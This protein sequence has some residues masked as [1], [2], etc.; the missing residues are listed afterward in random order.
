MCEPSPV[1]SWFLKT[2]LQ[3]DHLWGS[4]SASKW[5]SCGGVNNMPVWQRSLSCLDNKLTACERH[6][7]PIFYE[8]LSLNWWRR[9]R[10]KQGV[11]EQ[12]DIF[13]TYISIYLDQNG[14][15]R[16]RSF[17]YSANS[18]FYFTNCAGA[19]AFLVCSFT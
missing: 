15:N 18:S 13:C 2:S 4:N 14:L 17:L 8:R 7:E 1:L 6:P 19:C 10:Q 3:T 12:G 5:D 11:Q 16:W 9:V